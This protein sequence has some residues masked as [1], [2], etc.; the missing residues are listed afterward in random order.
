MHNVESS[1]GGGLKAAFRA[2]CEQGV[3]VVV[4]AGKDVDPELDLTQCGKPRAG[5]PRPRTVLRHLVVPLPPASAL[6]DFRN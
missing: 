3:V 1:H 4:V 6:F 2:Q 5:E